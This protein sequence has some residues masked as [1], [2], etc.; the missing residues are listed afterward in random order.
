MRHLFGFLCACALVGVV[1]IACGLMDPCRGVSC[2]DGNPCTWDKCVVG[3]DDSTSCDHGWVENGTGC[4]LHG[5]SGV[6]ISGYCDLCE[7]VVCEDDGNECIDD[8]CDRNTGGC[9]VPTDDGTVC[10][11]KGFFAGFC[12]SGFCAKSL[13]DDGICD[14]GN[15]CTDDTCDTISR[16]CDYVPVEDHTGCDFDGLDGFCIDGACKEHLCEGVVCDDQNACTDDT[17]DFANGSC[18]LIAVEDGTPCDL[19]GFGSVCLSGVCQPECE[20]VEDCDDQNDCT[21]DLCVDGMCEFVPVTDGTP[22]RDG[23]G[24]CQA[25]SCVDE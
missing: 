15:Q 20:M 8:V 6:C 12:A 9:G 21:Q 11:Y 22:C 1:G 4:S 5:A 2:S 17:C 24:A 14:D 19:D 3:C 10:Q 16:R 7:G 18:G 25:G 23:T 13:C